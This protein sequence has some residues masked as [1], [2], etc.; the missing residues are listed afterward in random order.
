MVRY[1]CGSVAV[2]LLVYLDSVLYAYENPLNRIENIT[3]IQIM[4]VRHH[5][6]FNK[7]AISLILSLLY[8]IAYLL[9]CYILLNIVSCIYLTIYSTG[10]K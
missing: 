6:C 3:E 7:N 4:Q 10:F 2:I 8:T 9:Y 1:G 5:F